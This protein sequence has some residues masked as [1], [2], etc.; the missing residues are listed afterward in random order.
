MSVIVIQVL[1][2]GIIFAADRN[3]TEFDTTTMKPIKQFESTKVKKTQ[4]GRH[5]VGYVGAARIAGRDSLEY[6]ID[7]VESKETGNDLDQLAKLVHD[8]VEAQ[9]AKDDQ[10]GEPSELIV[11]IAGIKK[12]EDIPVPEVYYISNCWS[13]IKGSYRDIRKEFGCSDE[14]RVKSEEARVKPSNLKAWLSAMSTTNQ[15][16]G[17]QHAIGLQNF[18]IIDN[19]LKVT[20]QALATQNNLPNPTN[21]QQWQSQARMSVLTYGAFFERFYGTNEQYVGGGVDV[22]SLDW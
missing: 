15:P 10:G 18:V 2:F 8:E 17:F 9:H 1:P 3:V 14:V 20:L 22:I 13:L 21:L 19:M 5:L 6:L 16:F 4:S 12:R 11:S 7:F